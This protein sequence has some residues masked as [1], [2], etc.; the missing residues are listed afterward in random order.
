MDGQGGF[1]ELYDTDEFRL[2]C[3]KILPCSKRM[4]HNWQQCVFA[5]WGEKARRRDLR[6][7]T[8]S[9]QLCPDAKREGGCPKGD[10]CSMSHNIFEAWLHP[11]LYRT[12]LCTSGASCNRTVCFFAHSQAELRQPS[13]PC[14]QQQQ[15]TTCPTA[16]AAA[17]APK[18]QQSQGA[19][20]RSNVAAAAAAAAAGRATTYVPSMQPWTSSSSSNSNAALAPALS[21]PSQHSNMQQQQQQQLGFISGFDALDS[22]AVIPHNSNCLLACDSSLDCLSLAGTGSSSSGWSSSSSS[23]GC[24]SPTASTPT[25]INSSC[26]MLADGLPGTAAAAAAALPAPAVY[27]G[28]SSSMAM[29]N[30][31]ADLAMALQQLKLVPDGPAVVVSGPAAPNALTSGMMFEF[32]SNI[33]NSYTTGFPTDRKSVV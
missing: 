17:A 29:T 30:G 33:P 25:N 23:A 2:Y 7:H 16:A 18:Q 32:Q 11:E 9:S 14:Q 19:L 13:Q 5:H 15:Q 26:V 31:S 12:Q 1:A 10:A 27:R 6:T 3:F 21:L 24:G 28:S 20:L 4:P 8:Y 22:L